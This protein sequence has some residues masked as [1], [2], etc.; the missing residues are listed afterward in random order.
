MSQTSRSVLVVDE[1]SFFKQK[2]AALLQPRGYEILPAGTG[3]EAHEIMAKTR[4]VLAIVDH[5]LP[6]G[7]GIHWVQQIRN[8]GNYLPIV[9]ITGNFCDARTFNWLRNI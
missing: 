8:Q 4:P 5:R 6:D 1:D 9:F 2:V 3:Q 7:D